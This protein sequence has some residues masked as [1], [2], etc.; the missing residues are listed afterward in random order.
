MQE[1]QSGLHEQTVNRAAEIGIKSTL[2]E[3]EDLQVSVHTDPL[4]LLSGKLDTVEIWGEGLVMKQD[5]RME[6]LEVETDEIAIN[7]L[8]AACG[9]IE[10]EQPTNAVVRVVL[11]EADINR[12]FASDYIST[13][14]QNLPVNVDGK[15]MTV[16]TQT[17]DFSLPGD[18]K[19]AIAAKV[20]LRETGEIERVAFTAVPHVRS[21]RNGATLTQVHYGEIKELSPELTAALV[22]KADDILNLRSFEQTGISLWLNDLQVEEKQIKLQAQAYIEEIPTA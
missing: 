3:V 9:Q 20:L 5:L 6:K 15:P 21:D 4:A 17:V 8:R 14:L 18:G 19:V 12:A 10:L 13:K 7:T 11:T 16:D 22:E 1:E 2:S